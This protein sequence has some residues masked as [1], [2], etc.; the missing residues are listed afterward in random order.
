MRFWFP[1]GSDDDVGG[2]GEIS[3]ATSG[4]IL[5][6]LLFSGGGG[7]DGTESEEESRRRF[8]LCFFVGMELLCFPLVAFLS[9]L[10]SWSSTADLLSDWIALGFHGGLPHFGVV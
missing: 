1:D 3:G 6:P 9:G 4:R 8:V 10:V 7:G 2:S 5:F